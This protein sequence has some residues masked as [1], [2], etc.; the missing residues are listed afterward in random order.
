MRSIFSIFFKKNLIFKIGQNIYATI[1]I[2]S[3]V[4]LFC[5]ETKFKREAYESYALPPQ[6]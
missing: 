1:K 6:R 2:D 5:S 3:K 4:I